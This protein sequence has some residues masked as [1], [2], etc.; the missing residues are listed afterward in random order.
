MFCDDNDDA[1]DG[2]SNGD[3]N[4]AAA[5]MPLEDSATTTN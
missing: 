3:G 2:D 1:E 4:A 5:A